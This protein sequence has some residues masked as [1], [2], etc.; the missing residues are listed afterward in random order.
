[1]YCLVTFRLVFQEACAHYNLLFVTVAS[2]KVNDFI[3]LI[4][5]VVIDKGDKGELFFSL[6]YCCF[7][8]KLLFHVSDHMIYD[9]LIYD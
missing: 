4:F 5:A 9:V 6:I 3:V 7:S 1:M 2:V 8:V